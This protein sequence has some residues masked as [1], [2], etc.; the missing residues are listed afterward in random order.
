MSDSTTITIRV[1]RSVKE[2][3]EAIARQTKRSKSYLAGEAIEE[4]LAV[5]EWQV[6]GIERALHSLDD[7]RGVPHDDVSSWVRSWDTD[8]ERP[9]P[10]R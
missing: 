3:L 2:R 9:K 10:K 5:Q 7:G 6:E 4:F 1:D 8:D